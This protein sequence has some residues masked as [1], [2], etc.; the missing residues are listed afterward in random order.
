MPQSEKLEV[1]DYF[2]KINEKFQAETSPNEAVLVVVKSYREEGC[3]LH[4]VR[5]LPQLAPKVHLYFGVLRDR[6]PFSVVDR[7]NIFGG[8]T[9]FV[10]QCVDWWGY[11]FRLRKGKPISL[12]LLN[13][14]GNNPNKPIY[15]SDNDWA[16]WQVKKEKA[17]TKKPDFPLEIIVGH[18]KIQAYCAQSK[19]LGAIDFYL[20]VLCLLRITHVKLPPAIEEYVQN[21]KEGILAGLLKLVSEEE[22]L[23]REI[24]GI[25]DSKKSGQHYEGGGKEVVE[26]DDDAFVFSLGQRADLGEIRDGIRRLLKKALEFEMDKLSWVK[27]FDEKPGFLINVPDFI[28]GLCSRVKIQE[29]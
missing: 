22:K 6:E 18:E 27:S 3:T 7:K 14:D 16:H 11:D 23:V 19:V 1:P 20:K 9:I 13:L 24:K 5:L 12:S 2:G 26:D 4:R 21:E 29:K 17:G 28:R 25:Y 10:A 15:S 8:I